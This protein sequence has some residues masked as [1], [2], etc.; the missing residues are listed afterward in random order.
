[1]TELSLRINRAL[2]EIA[3]ARALLSR[4]RRLLPREI[5]DPLLHERR[6]HTRLSSATALEFPS[7]VPLAFHSA[8]SP[9]PRPTPALWAGK[10][11]HAPARVPR[12]CDLRRTQLVHP[13]RSSDSI[14]SKI[15]LRAHRRTAL[16]RLCTAILTGSRGVQCKGLLSAT[17]ALR[18]LFFAMPDLARGQLRVRSQRPTTRGRP[19]PKVVKYLIG[20][21]HRCPQAQEARRPNITL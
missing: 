8:F 17:T 2:I 15:S 6:A 20:P 10:R 3:D 5:R 1:M 21:A 13:Q 16:K 4:I 9:M 18:W 19:A 14:A 12:S 7:S 11:G